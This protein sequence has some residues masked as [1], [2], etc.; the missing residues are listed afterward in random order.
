M[1]ILYSNHTYA[2]Q[3]NRKTIVSIRGNQ[4]F[5]NGELTYK[6]KYWK[7]NKIEGLLMNSRMVQGIFDDLNPVTQN[8]FRYPDTKKWDADRNT[9]EFVSA[10]PDWYH[11]GLLCFTLNLQGGSPLGYGNKGWINSAFDSGGALR[12]KYMERLER[13]LSKADELGMVVILGY[14]YFGQDEQL[15]DETAVINAVDNITRW[16][17]EKGYKNLLIEINNECDIYYDH[18]ILRPGS[19]HKLINSVKALSKDSSPLLVSTSFSGGTLPH[20]NVVQSSD[21]I[22]LHGNGV[23]SA[24][25]LNQ[26]IANT[27]KIQGFRNQ[28][29][30]IN[31]DDH[32]NFEADT[33]NFITAI[34]AYTSWG[35]FDYRMKDENIEDGYQ[36]IPVD[37]GIHS[38]RKIAFFS[39]LKEITSEEKATHINNRKVKY[40]KAKNK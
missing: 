12:I 30:I 33:S 17:A 40:S 16:I 7:G 13:I 24:L 9:N 21:Y 5:I 27:R 31:E 19:V 28:P 29:I 23:S 4:F 25:Q 1:L 20:E 6:N 8:Q 18:V 34:K 2:Q 26:L 14:F 39:K 11:Q 36:S 37:W 15:K 22:L 38:K 32:F 10:M 3:T 35:Y